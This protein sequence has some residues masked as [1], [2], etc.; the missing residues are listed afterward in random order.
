MK[1]H[2][3]M[4]FHTASS[5]GNPSG[6]GEKYVKRLHDERIP[7]A[8]TCADGTVGIGDALASPHPDDVLIFRVVRDGSEKYAVPDYGASPQDA[9]R[10]TWDLISP[11]I[12]RDRVVTENKDKIWLAYG[13]ELDQG[14]S[15]WIFKWSL[16]M[17]RLLNNQ[18]YKAVGPNWA[19]G[20]PDYP[21]WE[22]GAALDFLRYCGENPAKAA[23]GVHEYSYEVDDLFA[24]GGD[25]VGR[26]RHI[27]K[28][29]QGHQIARPTILI[30]EF[31]YTYNAVPEAS[32]IIDDLRKLFQ[33]Y[34]DY[35]PATLW[36]LGPDYGQI[37]N[38]LQKAIGDVG[39]FVAGLEVEVDLATSIETEKPKMKPS[40]GGGEKDEVKAPSG[41][42]DKFLWS[43]GTKQRVLSL[44]PNAA[45]QK[46]IF[47]D[48]FV[49]VSSE[50]QTSFKDQ[51][52]AIQ[53]AEHIGTGETRVY[54]AAVGAWGDVRFVTSPQPVTPIITGSTEK[55]KELETKLHDDLTAPTTDLVKGF[56][57]ASS[58]EIRA[59]HLA[60]AKI[61]SLN[62]REKADQNSALKGV[63]AKGS[64]VR[65]LRDV[66]ENGYVYC[67]A[68]VP[69][70]ATIDL[71]DYIAGDGRQYEVRGDKGSQERFQT[72]REGSIF[73]QVKNT[74]WEQMSF[75]DDFI[76][77]D[78][79][80]SPGGG[81]YYRL[82]DDDRPA[83]SRWLR[84]RMSVGER[85]SQARQ[86][87]FYN[88]K[89]GSKSDENSGRVVDTMELTAH[90][91]K[92]KFQT[93]IELADVVEL[94]WVNGGERYFYARKYGL[95]GWARSHFDPNS[96][97][98]S[99]ISEEHAPGTV[100]P[101]KRE[102]VTIK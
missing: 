23:V 28:V 48:G 11:F 49:P 97:A 57:W 77:R 72:Q 42:L 12:A 24:G 68:S 32:K 13:N 61:D 14:N 89:D 8:I 98:W 39:N 75:D 71:L 65:V 93:G 31:G 80:I 36:W 102:T 37:A 10:K 7:V 26:Y 27:V 79:D 44:N 66:P 58:L 78:I 25:K 54:Y 51:P 19:A 86:V 55:P 18:G 64:I 21:A 87:Q 60:L 81:R 82:K 90:H 100:A 34:P 43:E 69:Q 74:Q 56:V 5:G 29:C 50:N 15:E 94:L 30:K 16:E 6:I 96:P 63:L 17:C 1:M 20:T 95:V 22:T 88:K 3:R 70:P 33:L 52:Y 46:I 76:Y 59:N 40:T 91:G 83:G 9:A 53:A 41:E 101:F 67:E 47:R 2:P 99:A 73:Y 92:Y 35:P 84:R 4:G 38:Q 85:Y 45:L 62:L